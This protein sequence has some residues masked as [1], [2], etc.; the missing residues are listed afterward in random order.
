MAT[1]VQLKIVT[2]ERLV[3]DST[4][5]EIELPG[6][7]GYLDVLPSHAP[8]LT[9]LGV[10]EIRYRQSGNTHYLAVAWGFAEI[11]AERVTILAEICERAS[12]IDVSRA[13][14]AKQ[15]AELRLTSHDASIDQNRARKALQRA[16]IRIHV[17]S[18]R[19]PKDAIHLNPLDSTAGPR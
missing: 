14:A 8:L 6:K 15:R 18:K 17:A 13:R 4:A 10:G 7:D 9:A 12:E 5:E 2:P 19:N 1:I 16:E 11:L 3:V